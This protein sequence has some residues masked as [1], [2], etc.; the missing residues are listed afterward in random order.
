MKAIEIP[1]WINSYTFNHTYSPSFSINI[2]PGEIVHAKSSICEGTLE[3]PFTI[4]LSSEDKAKEMTGTGVW[5][6]VSTWD[7]CHKITYVK[8]K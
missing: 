7:L 8:D 6:G 1:P 5:R 4:Y 2:N 3:V